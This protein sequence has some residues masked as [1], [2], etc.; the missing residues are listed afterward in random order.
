MEAKAIADALQRSFRV[1]WVRHCSE[2]VKRLACE[3]TREE[4][5]EEQGSRVFS[6]VLVDLFLADSQGIE[7]FDR[8]SRAAPRIP[9]LVLCAERNEDVAKLAVQRGAPDYLLKAHIDGYWFPKAVHEMVERATRSEALFDEKERALVTLKTIGDAVITTDVWGHVASLNGVAERLTGWSYVE[10]LGRPIGAVF[11][12]I[13]ATTRDSMPIDLASPLREAEAVALTRNG[14][15]LRRNGTEAAV[16]GSVAPI[17][18]RRGHLIGAVIAFHDVSAAH[19]SSLRMSFLAQHDGL[20]NLPNRV[21]CG[22]RLAEAIVLAGRHRRKLAVLHLD[23]DRFK[24]IN[25]SLGFDIGDRLLQSMA[26]QL[27]DCVRSVD[28]VSRAGG[29]EFVVLLA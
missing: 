18:N 19:A 12:I 10:A 7:T 25:D 3:E 8:L 6:A 24:H 15:L 2:G 9:T 13:D 5:R 26:T 28:T 1:A 22:E 4:T 16:E 29:D 11:R 23:V 17:H 20:T 21:L 14:L 27:H